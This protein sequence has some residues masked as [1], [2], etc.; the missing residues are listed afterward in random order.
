MTL[1]GIKNNRMK[2]LI[3]LIVCL[4]VLTG[5]A[6]QVNPQVTAVPT[7]LAAKADPNQ[8]TSDIGFFFDT[9]VTVTFYGA[10]EGLMDE[11]WAA[12]AYYE[13][14][15][16]K[17]VTNSDVDRI[18]KSAGR[19]TMVSGDTWNILKKAKEIS[20]M[21]DGAFSMTIAP[22]SAMWDFTGDSKA[23]PTDEERIAALPLVD[24]QKIVLGKNNTVQLPA[25]MMIDLGGIAKGFIAD[26]MA[27]LVRGRCACAI[28]NLG[29]NVYVLGQK[30]DGTKNSIGV[31]DP[32]G[33]SASEYMAIIRTLDNSVVT[34]GTYERFF[35]LDGVRYHH[36]LDPRTGTSATSDLVSATFVME[37]SMVADAY[38]TACIVKGSEWSLKFANE[39]GLDA[40]FIKTDGSVILSDSFTSRHVFELYQ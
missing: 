10:E 24:D 33:E 1:K 39:H 4:L 9:V 3:A 28:L 25:G 37:S 11:L 2:K 36:I 31:R 8:K 27:E 14:M 19:L 30:P 13:N 16:S 18:N 40:V 38:A 15:L 23:M 5:C 17:T 29:G 21:T 12:C 22:I 20:A 34:S 32:W 35:D 7:A 26:K 6:G